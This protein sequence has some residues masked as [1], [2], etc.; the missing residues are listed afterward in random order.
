MKR[1]A[2]FNSEDHD[3][4]EEASSKLDKA[5]QLIRD[6]GR[7]VDRVKAPI[8]ATEEDYNTAMDGVEAF[9]NAVDSDIGFEVKY[10]NKR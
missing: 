9:K 3:N 8:K 6:A 5:L 2:D 10:G 1:D 7:A 4:L